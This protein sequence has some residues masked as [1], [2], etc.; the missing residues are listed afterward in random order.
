MTFGISFRSSPRGARRLCTERMA[1]RGKHTSSRNETVLPAPCQTSCRERV[2]DLETVVRSHKI[3][4]DRSSLRA[5]C[6]LP[7]QNLWLDPWDAKAVRVCFACA[8][9]SYRAARGD[10]RLGT[11]SAFDAGAVA[12]Q[13]KRTRSSLSA[14]TDNVHGLDIMLLPA[15]HIFGS[16]QIFLRNRDGSLLYTG[17]FKLRPG[18]PP[19]RRNGGRPTR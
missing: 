11:N 4:R 13:T 9:R 3:Q 15:G 18:N 16:A 1:T 14:K 10:H 2:C 19:S 5:R 6:F 17:D 7:Q 8:Q 12:G